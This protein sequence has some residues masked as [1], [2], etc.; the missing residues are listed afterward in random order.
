M[1]MLV[2]K[3]GSELVWNRGIYS[4]TKCHK[5][6][7]NTDATTN[8][9]KIGIVWSFVEDDYVNKILFLRCMGYHFIHTS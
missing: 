1:I 5:N 9:I 8:I 3:N 6:S 7:K 2:I 4:L